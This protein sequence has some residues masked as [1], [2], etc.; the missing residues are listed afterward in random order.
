MIRW[1][2]LEHVLVWHINLVKVLL[3]QQ[4][5]GP[6][7]C[8][9]L[10]AAGDVAYASCPVEWVEGYHSARECKVLHRYSSP[11]CSWEGGWTCFR[12]SDSFGVRCM[13]LVVSAQ[14]ALSLGLLRLDIPSLP[15]EDEGGLP[16][17]A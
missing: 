15:G 7:G 4:V 10:L 13:W 14:C 5:L 3:F 16:K 1:L 12:D 17:A 6:T 11:Q 9:N 8:S 2:V